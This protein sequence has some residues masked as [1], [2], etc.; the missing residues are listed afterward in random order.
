M[1]PMWATCS[2]FD[3]EGG[4]CYSLS[5]QAAYLGLGG[6]Q[7][8]RLGSGATGATGPG[9]PSG[10]SGPAGVTGATGPQGNAGPAGNT[11]ATGPQGPSGPSGPAGSGGG[12]GGWTTVRQTVDVPS[13]STAFA[14]LTGLSWPVAALQKLE[15]T[16]ILP[17]TVGATTTGVRF[18]ATAPAGATL[19]AYHT[20]ASDTIGT[21]DSMGGAANDTGTATATSMATTGNVARMTGALHNGATAGTVQIRFSSEVAALATAKAG[22]SCDWRAW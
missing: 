3:A 1:L 17:W 4:L 16:C 19:F 21:S 8:L 7:R 9:G 12:S 14:S 6:G 2:A 13:S 11:G 18:A 5:E 10:P 22:A 20:I 15:W